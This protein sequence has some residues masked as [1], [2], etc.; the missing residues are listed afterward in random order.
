MGRFKSLLQK[1]FLFIFI[2]LI[3]VFL[4]NIGLSLLLKNKIEN[5]DKEYTINIKEAKVNILTQSIT[6]NNIV[7]NSSKKEKDSLYLETAQLYINGISINDILNPQNIDL[8]NIEIKSPR[9]IIFKGEDTTSGNN[10]TLKKLKSFKVKE[11]NIQNGEITYL[12]FKRDT[13]W[14]IEKVNLKYKDFR[15]DSNTIKNRLPYKYSEQIADLK[16]M[17]LKMNEYQ[18]LFIKNL[19]LKNTKATIQNLQI[20]PEYSKQEFQTKITKEKDWIK[21]NVKKLIINDINLNEKEIVFGSKHIAIDSASLYIY[22][23]KLLPDQTTYKPL[24]SKM[25]RELPFKINIDSVK[26]KNSSIVYEERIHAEGKPGRL[27][28]TQFNSLIKNINNKDNS[29]IT[30]LNIQTRFMNSAT[31]HVN[32]SFEVANTADYFNIQGKLLS[33]D[34]S[35]ANKFVTP[36]LNSKAEGVINSLDFD[37]K[38]NDIIA[39]GDIEMKYEGLKFEIINKDKSK[40]NKFLSSLANLFVKKNKKVPEIK[41]IQVERDQQKSFFNYFW[42]CIEEG[43]MATIL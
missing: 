35:Y 36:N 7:I 5:I 1:V 2:T 13:T 17:Q 23:N 37:I 3:L 26:I 15:I 28:F 32:W 27:E 10:N 39:H 11:I 22:R 31:F 9:I 33:F 18:K 24:Y 21:L 19:S 16:N 30:E 34:T 4:T 14:H 20:N 29:G 38:G 40:V 25:L 42:L 43:V 12:N 6:V 41:Q 8:S